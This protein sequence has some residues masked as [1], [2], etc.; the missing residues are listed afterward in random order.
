M[1]ALLVLALLTR[2]AFAHPPPPP[3]DDYEGGSWRDHPGRIEWSTWLR[4]GYGAAYERSDTAARTT[5]P[6][7]GEDRRHG[8]W[9]FGVGAEA[10]LVLTRYSRVGAWAELRGREGFGGG[11]LIITGAPRSID[12][13]LYKGEG[14]LALRGGIGPDQQ[15]TAAIAYGYRCPWKLFGDAPRSTRYQIGA[16]F[17]VTFTRSPTEWSSTLGIE[18]EPVGA[19]RYLLGIRSWY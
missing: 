8:R 1:R 18:V 9:D 6:P 17:A 16:R 13:F 15:Q 4:L 3:D 2:V 5:T 7:A 12:M 14:V 10:S 19:L 11:E